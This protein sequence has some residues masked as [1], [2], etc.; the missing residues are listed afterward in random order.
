MKERDRDD[1]VAK[2]DDLTSQWFVQRVGPFVSR[3]GGTWT[4]VG[5]SD[6]LDFGRSGVWQQLQHPA[7]R[8]LTE[9][10]LVPVDEDGTPIGYPPL[11]IHHW[12]LTPKW[13]MK[14]Q[15]MHTVLAQAHGDS[16]CGKES[17][18]AMCL[19]EKLPAGFGFAV[20]G[21]LSMD[22]DIVDVRPSGSPPLEFYLEVAAQLNSSDEVSLTE[23]WLTSIGNP[24]RFNLSLASEETQAAQLYFIP[25]LRAE[26]QKE[27]NG[28]MLWFSARFLAGGR[29]LWTYL[30]S[31]Q[32]AMRHVLVI[33]AHP[34]SL[35]L[36]QGPFVLTRPWEPLS[37]DQIGQTPEDAVN[38]L[39]GGL[40]FSRCRP[41][42]SAQGLELSLLRRISTIR[43]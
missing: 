6:V 13:A 38:H 10:L 24:F 40:P 25:A 41:L 1:L 11:H 16:Q 31:H 37:L 36:N 4:Q 18:G 30:H 35:C 42:N 14:Y 32:V 28:H 7:T 23:L 2:I 33:A 20:S 27:T 34:D 5:V 22:A 8:L 29:Y 43:V 26:S 39:L 3:G 19:L 21:E 12:H 9:L 17:G 15:F